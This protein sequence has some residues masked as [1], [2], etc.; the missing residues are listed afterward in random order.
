LIFG[1]SA[2]KCATARLAQCHGTALLCDNK[3]GWISG[4]DDFKRWNVDALRTYCKK[5][6][7]QVARCK[8]KEELVALAYAAFSQNYPLVQ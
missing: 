6:G 8:K 4:I 1:A 5:R 3:H 2:H 7:L